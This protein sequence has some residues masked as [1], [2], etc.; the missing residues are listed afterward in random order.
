MNIMKM[1]LDTIVEAM[2]L[3]K[4][5]HT[6]NVFGDDKELFTKTSLSLWI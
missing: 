3:E 6:K 4:L 2:D 1:S 5:T